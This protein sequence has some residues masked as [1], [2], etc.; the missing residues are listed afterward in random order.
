VESWMESL[1]CSYSYY[2]FEIDVDL[3]Y[4]GKGLGTYTVMTDQGIRLQM[5]AG[6]ALNWGVLEIRKS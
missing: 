1:N 5:S 4:S 2:P 3:T 6:I